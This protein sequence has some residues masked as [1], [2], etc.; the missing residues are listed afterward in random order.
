ML[1]FIKWR[2][3]NSRLPVA[4]KQ[5][6]HDF[7]LLI[8]LF[9]LILS[10][11]S[12][13]GFW[14]LGLPQSS[15]WWTPCCLYFAGQVAAQAVTNVWAWQRHVVCARK[16]N[17]SSATLLLMVV[18]SG[19]AGPFQETPGWLWGF[20]VSSGGKSTDRRFVIAT[21]IGQW[22]ERP[23]HQHTNTL[24]C[25]YTKLFDSSKA[26]I[27]D[28]SQFYRQPSSMIFSVHLSCDQHQLLLWSIGN[29]AVTFANVY[30]VQ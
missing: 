21:V 4:K 25:F 1:D 10:S 26:P 30:D 13:T 7:E 11:Q 5:K 14:L 9:H 15:N 3:L 17:R 8:I 6:K 16:R 2:V 20:D 27:V 19:A 29:Y 22:E 28:I 24:L 18:Q 23:S 12:T